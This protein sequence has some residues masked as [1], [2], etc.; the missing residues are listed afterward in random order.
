MSDYGRLKVLVAGG[1]GYIGSVVAA[2]LV[3]NGH[4]VTVLDSLATG[5]RDAVHPDVRFIP[6]G[7]EDAGAV[8]DACKD[9]IDV[10]MHFAACIQVG[11]SVADP[12][13]YY[14]NNVVNTIRFIDALRG[15]EI[16]AL[17]FSSTAAVYGEPERVPLSEDDP[18]LP[19]NPYGWTK[20]M[21]EQVLSDYD[22]AYGFRSVRLR[23][24]NVGGAHGAWGEDHRPE[25]HL[26]PLVLRAIETGDPLTVFGTDYPTRDG[27]P[28]RD[29]FHVADLAE[30]H[31][32][33]A[34][35]LAAG[36]ATDAFNLG[37]GTGY[38]V[39][40]VIHA[41]ERVTG[42]AVPYRT[43]GR[44]PGDSAALVASADRAVR[45]LGWRG[46]RLTLDDIIGSAWEWRRMHPK[47]YEL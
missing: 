22:A 40:E 2:L 11:E 5:H 15:N 14:R 38:S 13:I 27:S 37:T 32:L 35:Y 20:R 25:S 39:L 7:I 31:L 8:K 41:A 21:V 43:A 3:E 26:V 18:L 17:V 6:A 23:Y 36:N 47:G 29:Y 44:R 19:V 9:G 24:F 33:A 42:R 4:S 12:S 1:A 16:N 34:K 46:A 28:I 30:A 10:A 45:V